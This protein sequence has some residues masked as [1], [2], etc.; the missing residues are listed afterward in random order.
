MLLLYPTRRI[1]VIIIILICRPPSSVRSLYWTKDLLD[2]VKIRRWRGA[3]KTP[4]TVPAMFKK[5]MEKNKSQRALAI[6][7]VS[8][9]ETV[10]G[11]N[12]VSVARSWTYGEY[13]DDCI[14]AAKGL[15]RV[16]SCYAFISSI[17]IPL[18]HGLEIHH[19]V[20]CILDDRSPTWHIINMAA[21]MAGY[22]EYFCLLLI[23]N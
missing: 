22:V 10:V 7:I 1:H 17:L 14:L 20:M 6:P 21:I 11:K 9:E 5:M 8:Y 4:V 15:I 3:S 16:K 13:Y 2:N 19:S 23:V 18:Q 12:I